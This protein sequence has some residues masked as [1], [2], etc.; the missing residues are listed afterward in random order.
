MGYLAV[1]KILEEMI[2][3]FRKRGATVPSDI[4][5]KIR[6][7]KTLINVLKA[8]PSKKETGQKIEEH[9]LGIQSYL[10]SEGEKQFG[11][12][13]VERWLQRLDKAGKKA[14]EGEGRETRF[15]SGIPRDQKWIRVEP[16]AEL[17]ID[18]LKDLVNELDLSYDIQDDGCMLVYGE[19][20]DV[21]CFVR[22]MTAKYGSKS[23]RRP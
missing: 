6:S 22:E 13:Y 23:R 5:N 19:E 4:M 1:W 7:A 15:V 14:L 11:E 16:S 8:D 12:G 20:E 18:G 9:L 10:V 21:K 2:I 17:P 3:D